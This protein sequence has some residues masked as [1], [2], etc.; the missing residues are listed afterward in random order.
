ME[1]LNLEKLCAVKVRIMRDRLVIESQE[2]CYNCPGYN[3]NCNHYIPYKNG[4]S[5]PVR[6]GIVAYRIE[7]GSRKY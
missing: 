5:I 6:Q 4:C 7:N 3:E 1:D 2:R